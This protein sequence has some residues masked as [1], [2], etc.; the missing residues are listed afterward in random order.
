M[1][2]KHT[3][4]YKS[5]FFFFSLSFSISLSLSLLLS[6]FRSCMQWWKILPPTYKFF[7]IVIILLVFLVLY[8]YLQKLVNYVRGSIDHGKN[9]Q[10]YV[11]NPE[12][13]LPPSASILH[14]FKHGVVCSDSRECSKIGRF[15]CLYFP[16]FQMIC[17]PQQ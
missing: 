17:V 1:T 9:V 11:P 2:C 12:L 8:L 7:L 4:I 14:Q 10:K 15:V 3:N 16:R 13:P 5:I 6:I